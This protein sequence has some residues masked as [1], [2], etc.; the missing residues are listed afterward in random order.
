MQSEIE[1]LE[2]NETKNIPDGS[3][4]L[5][6]EIE[7]LR[8]KLR[9]ARKESNEIMNKTNEFLDNTEKM[10][11]SKE[12][13]MVNI[14]LLKQQNEALRKQL[15]DQDRI[16][17]TEIR[18]YE[19][20]LKLQEID[21]SN[22][23]PQIQQKVP[24]NNSDINE[25]NKQNIT[26]DMEYSRK[27]MEEINDFD[28]SDEDNIDS[29][30]LVK[31]ESK[32]NSHI[33]KAI[34]EEKKLNINQ[35]N[36]DIDWGEDDFNF[37]G[38]DNMNTDNKNIKKEYKPIFEEKKQTIN[39]ADNWIKDDDSFNP[40][41]KTNPEP[42]IK[43]NISNTIVEN[44]KV[45]NCKQTEEK[46]FPVSQDNYDIDW[47]NDNLDDWDIGGAKIENNSKE[48]NNPVIPA[49]IT[50][51]VKSII[52]NTTK[53][54]IKANPKPAIN[55]TPKTNIIP[56]SNIEESKSSI[57]QAN[58][59]IDWGGDDFDFS[60]EI[61][62][63]PILKT[64][65]KMNTEIIT[66]KPL[67]Q[68]HQ[69]INNNEKTNEIDWGADE[70]NIDE[71]FINDDAN[72]NQSIYSKST[73]E[74]SKLHNNST[75]S[76]PT[77]TSS[78]ANL[79]REKIKLSN[80][81]IPNPYSKINQQENEINWDNNDLDFAEQIKAP[82]MD[83]MQV[84]NKKLP[85]ASSTNKSTIKSVP[86]KNE[87]VSNTIPKSDANL[88][89]M[90][91]LDGI[92]WGNGD[93]DL[94]N[95]IASKDSQSKTQARTDTNSMSKSIPSNYEFTNQPN[96]NKSEEDKDEE[97]GTPKFNTKSQ[98][99]DDANKIDWG[100]ET[101][102]LGETLKEGTANSK[103]IIQLVNPISNTIAKQ[104]KVS[105]INNETN[106]ANDKLNI[107]K[108]IDKFKTKPLKKME[109]FDEIIKKNSSIDNIMPG[110]YEALKQPV[111]ID[112]GNDEFDINEPIKNLDTINKVVPKQSVNQYNAVKS[113]T[114]IDWGNDEFNLNDPINPMYSS[115]K[116]QNQTN[117]CNYK[118]SNLIRNTNPVPT[119]NPNI[120]NTIPANN[121]TK[122]DDSNFNLEFDDKKNKNFNLVD[123]SYKGGMVKPTV[124]NQKLEQKPVKTEIKS[125]GTTDNKFKKSAK[126]TVVPDSLF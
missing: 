65:T 66:T 20:K 107:D 76:N 39:Q 79:P 84:T 35:G 125:Y 71:E 124:L 27:A 110:K 106:L 5:D 46:K 1:K 118:S 92:D 26:R 112:W 19:N 14:E 67:E 56:K 122:W 80:S 6:N 51:N 120:M 32:S 121:E 10:Q 53:P 21:K 93:F 90:K 4:E 42:I 29:N 30:S 75:I 74:I 57:N 25:T 2:S 58:N 81:I 78:K 62:A 119:I 70:F 102:D 88:N 11:K 12:D 116:S 69:V 72:S 98:K 109:R 83:T 18:E 15:Q 85:I 61:N 41:I 52:K 123:S 33:N 23:K 99:I 28:Y 60:K 40:E 96:D 126:I 9:E 89:K 47:G 103:P 7:Q 111:D 3:S 22:I 73:Q 63:P 115:S 91:T 50:E 94:D 49:N 87:M 8:E 24:M 113:T 45:D 17:Q 38:K 36:N 13:I 117:E 68:K 77:H 108:T 48:I 95:E 43:S 55:E 34:T 44:N 97:H 86:I 105:K 54:I 16:Y 101:F 82:S 64:E 104:H 100:A 31:V 37:D 114:E 59:E